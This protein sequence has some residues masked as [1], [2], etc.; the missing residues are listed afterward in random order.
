[1]SKKR[2]DRKES[3]KALRE[4]RCILCNRL[5]DKRSHPICDDCADALVKSRRN[6]ARTS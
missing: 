1:M 5:R 4:V 6:S 3:L 2:P